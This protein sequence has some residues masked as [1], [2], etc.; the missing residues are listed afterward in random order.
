MYRNTGNNI[1]ATDTLKSDI[2]KFIFICE[3]TAVI[4]DIIIILLN[5]FVFIIVIFIIL[6]IKFHISSEIIM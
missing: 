1:I 2:S 5:L 6:A 3:V 4:K